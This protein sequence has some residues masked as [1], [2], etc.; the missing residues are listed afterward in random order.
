VALSGILIGLARIQ[1]LAKPIDAIEDF[2]F[3]GV[4]RH[5][6]DWLIAV[7]VVPPFVRTVWRCIAMALMLAWYQ[8]LLLRLSGLR[9]A[10]WIGIV[11]FCIFAL[12]RI[13]FPWHPIVTIGMAAALP[14]VALIG[15]RSRPWMA[16]FAGTLFA[17]SLWLL[18]N[19]AWLF[20]AMWLV[21]RNS[22]LEA[23]T[24]NSISIALLS[25]NVAYAAVLLYGTDLNR[26]QAKA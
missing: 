9:C 8:P 14:C 20:I 26:S 25:G 1:V 5:V 24:A 6:T 7:I 4:W 11:A 19:D 21:F 2:I 23:Q 15:S 12:N 16:L 10:A 3:N 17:A 22:V 13:A 18:A